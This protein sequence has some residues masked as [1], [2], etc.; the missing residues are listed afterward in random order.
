M[1]LPRFL[2]LFRTRLILM[3]CL[4]GLPSLALVQNSYWEQRKSE[5]ARVRTEAMAVSRIAAANQE[6]YLKNSRQLL[7]TLTELAFLVNSSDRAFCRTS[8]FN[9]RK[10]APDYEGFGLIESNGTLFALPTLPI[11]PFISATGPIS[12]APWKQKSLQS[13]IFKSAVCLTNLP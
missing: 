12:A 6:N 10:L 5:Q 11:P 8:F 9:L 3:I 7:A 13:E 1:T 4:V 2:T